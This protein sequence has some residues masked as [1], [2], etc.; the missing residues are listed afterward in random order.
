MIVIP[1]S[2]SENVT[3]PRPAPP[4]FASRQVPGAQYWCDVFWYVSCLWILSFASP[5]TVP[6]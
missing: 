4:L 3:A 6:G 1:S 5:W 2:E